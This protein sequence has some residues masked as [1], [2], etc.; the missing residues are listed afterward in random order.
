MKR[1]LLPILIS[2]NTFALNAVGQT[3][4][5]FAN[6]PVIDTLHATDSSETWTRWK[7]DPCVIHWRGDSLRAYYGTNNYGVNTQIGTAIS[8][9][10]I[11]WSE[12]KNSPVLGLG[13]PGSWDDSEVETPYVLYIQTNPDSMKYMMWYS[14]ATP[15]SNLLGS[16][17]LNLT[18]YQIGLAYSADGLNWTKY[19]DM[20][21]DSAPLF[22]ESD[23][24]VG[25][26]QWTGCNPT[27]TNEQMF[28][29]AE[30][31]VLYDNNTFRLYYIGFGCASAYCQPSGDLRYRVLYSESLD[32]IHWGP[33]TVILDIGPSGAFDCRVVYSPDVIKL[34]N[35]YWMFYAGG[36]DSTYNVW[37]CDMGLATSDDGIHFTKF[38]A[39][40]VIARVSGSWTDC[41]MNAANAIVV[42]DTLRVYYS[43]LVCDSITAPTIG[44]SYMAPGGQCCNVAG[45][46]N[47][48]G[49]YNIAD[50]TFG[51]ALIFSGGPAPLCQD[52]ADANGD[53]S[54]NIADVTY[55]IARIF[56]GGP[57]PV[58]GTTG[59]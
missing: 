14:G 1:L 22:A 24:V 4:S 10:G 5:E 8:I 11:D 15:D 46:A 38:L 58:C 30:P 57:A 36:A 45:D 23:P 27:V 18:I 33:Q 16:P 59:L 34:N 9:N 6:N 35:K 53:N 29:V 32:G 19:N 26:P 42:R 31:C 37:K 47:H 41:G 40:P 56:S 17:C 21:N 52:E 28:S 48:D 55:G 50:I 2:I 54:F 20:T 7:S 13:S 44:F 51:I 3:F 12:K 49:S 43:G 25:I 39:N